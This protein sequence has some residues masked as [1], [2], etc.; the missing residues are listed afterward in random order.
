MLYLP[1]VTNTGIAIHTYV[2]PAGDIEALSTIVPIPA[3]AD[4]CSVY[5]KLTSNTGTKSV[6]IKFRMVY[7]EVYG[8]W[9]TL[10]TVTATTSGAH[11]SKRLERDFSANWDPNASEIQLQYTKTSGTQITIYAG[12]NQNV[13]S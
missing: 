2:M 5:N 12:I 8:D 7:G 11:S 10:E 3:R 6:V 4:R 9:V 13:R 1:F